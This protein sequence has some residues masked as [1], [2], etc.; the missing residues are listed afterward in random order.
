M[1]SKSASAILTDLATLPLWVCGPDTPHIASIFLRT[2]EFLLVF[3]QPLSP[4]AVQVR[5]LRRIGARAL[6]VGQAVYGVLLDVYPFILYTRTR[7]GR[8]LIDLLQSQAA[9]TAPLVLDFAAIQNCRPA[10]RHRSRQRCCSDS[11]NG[12]VAGKSRSNM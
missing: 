4:H 9:A 5:Q 8:N 6:R 12:S 1:E 2:G 11:R 3:P 7:D 10:R